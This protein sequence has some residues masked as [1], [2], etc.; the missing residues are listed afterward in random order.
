M[1]DTTENMNQQQSSNAP[2]G[3]IV[4]AAP[5]QFVITQRRLAAMMPGVNL[6]PAAFDFVEQALRATPEI[7]VVDRIGPKGL[8]GALADGMMGVPNVLVARMADEKAEMLR[9]QGRGLLIVERDRPLYLEM[10]G[11]E[12]PELVMGTAPTGSPS[13]EVTVMVLGKNN[14]P[15]KDAEVSLYGSVSSAKSFTDDRGLASLTMAGESVNSVRGLYVKPRADY[16][17]FYQEQPALDP[18]QPNIVF[19]HPLADSFAGFPRQQILGWGQKAMR[20]DQLP[21]HYR[22]QGVKVAIVDTGAATTHADLQNIRFGFDVVNKRN[23]PGTWNQDSISHGSHCAGILAGGGNTGI[24]GFA[25][26]SE[27]HVCKLFPGGQVSQLIDAIEYCIEKQIDIVNLSVGG[28]DYSEALEQQILRA[29]RLGIACIVAAG[30][31]GGPVQY[32]ASSPNVL[33]V[34]AIGKLGEFPADSYHA[35][36]VLALDGM[37]FFSPRFT[38]YGPEVGVC[39]PGVAVVSCVP[40]NNYAVWDGTSLAAPHISGLAALVLAHHP[41]FQ[42]PFKSRNSNRVDRLFQILKASA[43]PVNVGDRRR[44]GFGLPDVLV[45]LGMAPPMSAFS[46]FAG[47]GMFN[48]YPQVSMPVW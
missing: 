1:P 15:L 13:I 46:M 42:G 11:P 43:Q 3:K 37:G 8:T 38:S 32:P 26:D 41:D 27:L 34:S 39:G 23:D 25:P 22:G 17:T 10:L 12:Q 20:L 44:T 14:A 35:E 7:D 29:R 5:K 45:A 47:M 48:A 33:A 28:N 36:T 30:N 18:N 9:Q 6:P 24:R 40:P 31:S 21:A 4:R 2:P 16:W 19:V